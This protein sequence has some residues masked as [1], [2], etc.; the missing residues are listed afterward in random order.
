LLFETVG[1]LYRGIVP[2]NL[3]PVSSAYREIAPSGPLAAFI[4]CFWAG[5]VLNDCTARVLPDGCADIL[6]VSG[7]SRRIETQIVGVMTR[8]RLVPL[9]AGTSILGI[10]FHPGMMSAVLGISI[11][12]LN[13]RIV[14]MHSVMASGAGEISRAGTARTS[15]ERRI[16]AIEDQLIDLPEISS[17]QIAIG[18][19]VGR[20]GQLSIKD[21]ADAAG[22]SERQLRRTCLKETGLSPKFLARILRFRDA[23]LRLR[24]GFNSAAAVAYRCGYFDEAHMI[25]DFREFAGMTPLEYSRAGA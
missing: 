16:A 21:F 10:R 2:I 23:A 8:P 25:R 9:T 15:I 17:V 19:V 14:A 7:N 24:M 20:K 3:D 4:E 12:P 18:E 6:F 1:A 11:R 5:D 22:V 13:D